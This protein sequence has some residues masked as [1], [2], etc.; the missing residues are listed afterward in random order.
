VVVRKR[1]ELRGEPGAILD[2]EDR[3]TVVRI[4]APGVALR[5]LTIR[6][7]G[8]DYLTEDAGVRI[9]HAASVRL[10]DVRLE[11]VLFGVFAA[12]ADGCVIERTT[13][14]GKDLPDVRRA[15]G[16]RLW[17]SSGCRIARNRIE[18][19]RD[20]VIWYSANTV[21]EDNV[22]RLGR[23]GL[24][25]MYSDHNR[26]RGNRFEDDQVGAAIMNSRDIQ[27]EGNSFSFANGPSAYGLLVKDADDVFIR[28]NRFVQ[29][30]TALFFDGAPQSRGGRV[31]VRHNLIARNDVGLALEPRSRGLAIWENAFIGNGVEVQMMGTGATDGNQWAVGGRGNYWSDAVVYDRD[32]DGVSDVPYRL[33]S[34]WEALA[35]RHPTLAF[36]AGTPAADAIDLGARL[37]PLFQPRPKLTDPAPLTR[38]PLDEWLTGE[39]P[40]RPALALAGL[41]L[42][43]LAAGGARAARRVLS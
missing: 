13:I 2:G 28:D 27:L 35:D 33:E 7:S 9:E 22:V 30:A 6:R 29:N 21:V 11:D 12:Q 3:G 26:F 40:H 17:Y 16:I 4:E 43:A 39:R 41:G 18:R 1:V 38:P 25:Y 8:A 36:F 31:E 19:G 20:L 37:F 5:G 23:Y 10:E 24:H 32:G 14:L 42:L 34:T 15:D